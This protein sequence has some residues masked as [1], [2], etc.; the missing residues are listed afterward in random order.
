[1]PRR[2]ST[3]YDADDPGTVINEFLITVFVPGIVLF[4]VL[5][6]SFRLVFNELLLSFGLVPIVHQPGAGAISAGYGRM[7][8][9]MVLTA[10]ALLPYIGLYLRFLRQPLK[11]RGLV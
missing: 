8:L 2:G 5:W 10:L 7:I 11:E 9:L 3:L 4:V 6:A 1:M